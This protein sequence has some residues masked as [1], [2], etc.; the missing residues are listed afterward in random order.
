VPL[1]AGGRPLGQTPDFYGGRS[2]AS[3]RSRVS[4]K[5]ECA[6]HENA[7][8]QLFSM[9]SKR[10]EGEWRVGPGR[11]VATKCAV[12]THVGLRCMARPFSMLRC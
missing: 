11:V 8:S 7:A 5:K 9:W 10:L 4:L 2:R 3:S 6:A 12:G 1:P